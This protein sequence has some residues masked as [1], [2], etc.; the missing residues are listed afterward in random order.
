MIEPLSPWSSPTVTLVPGAWP[1][2][3]NNGLLESLLLAACLASQQHA[4]V[5]QVRICSDKCTCCHTEQEAADQTFYPTQSQYIDT[6]PT[7]PSADPVMLGA[8][9]GSHLSTNFEVTGRPRP[10]KIPTTKACSRLAPAVLLSLP[11]PSLWNRGGS[12]GVKR[13]QIITVIVMYCVS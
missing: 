1:Y 8:W 5:S 6:G 9:Q 3:P 11:S 13:S 7:S 10:G 12:Q 4:S 2:S